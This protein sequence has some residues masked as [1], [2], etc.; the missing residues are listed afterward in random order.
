[1]AARF[2]QNT[3]YLA[4]FGGNRFVIYNEAT[5]QSQNEFLAPDESLPIDKFYHIKKQNTIV[6]T[7]GEQVWMLRHTKDHSLQS[8][9]PCDIVDRNYASLEHHPV[10]DMHLTHDE[11]YLMML[12]GDVIQNVLLDV[13]ENRGVVRHASEPWDFGI[14]VMIW[15]DIGYVR[16]VDNNNNIVSCM[17]ND[18]WGFSPFAIVLKEFHTSIKA[19]YDRHYFVDENDNWWKFWCAPLNGVIMVPKKT[20]PN[21]VCVADHTQLNGWMVVHPKGMPH[22]LFVA[23]GGTKKSSKVPRQSMFRG[24]DDT[25]A[26]FVD[27]HGRDKPVLRVLYPTSTDKLFSVA[28]DE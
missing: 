2:S 12:S 8:C 17:F 5:K 13:E 6:F 21:A 24:R 4:L 7:G 20:L 18:E 28:L 26:Y 3:P 25:P 1:M 23:R 9:F 15:D 27:A 10:K 11:R 16:S 22:E 14:R 19:I